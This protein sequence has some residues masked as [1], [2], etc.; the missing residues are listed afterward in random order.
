MGSG[1]IEC[2]QVPYNPLE[3]EVEQRILP[4][5]EE[6]Q[7]GVIAMR[8]LGSGSLMQRSPDLSGLGVQTWAEAL[9]KWCLS[10]PRITVA[11]PATSSPVHAAVNAG[12]GNEPWFDED[13][14]ARVIALLES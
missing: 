8:P 10:D 4:L 7:L 1:R 3:R 14:R 5:A 9:L 2:I 13:Q 12:A 11:I 6:A